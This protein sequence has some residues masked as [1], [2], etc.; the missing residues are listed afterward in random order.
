MQTASAFRVWVQGEE[1]A[2]HACLWRGEGGEEAARLAFGN[3]A[4][5][6]RVEPVT[7]R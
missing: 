2:P 7:S 3:R 4:L 5:I 1:G 6:I